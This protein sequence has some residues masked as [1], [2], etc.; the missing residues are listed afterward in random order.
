M[1]AVL[2]YAPLKYIRWITSNLIE[3]QYYMVTSLSSNSLSMIQCVY[4]ASAFER[5]PNL[6]F[7]LAFC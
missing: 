6:K 7:K 4:A 2:Y 3:F 1:L 5:S